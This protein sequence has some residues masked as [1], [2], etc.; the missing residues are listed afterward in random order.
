M[1][2]FLERKKDLT[3]YGAEQFFVALARAEKVLFD[4]PFTLANFEGNRDI[5]F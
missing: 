4:Q 3:E 5:A 1:I 2:Y